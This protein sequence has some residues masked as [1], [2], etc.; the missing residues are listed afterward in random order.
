MPG[1]RTAC[2]SLGVALV[3]VAGCSMPHDA[4]VRFDSPQERQVFQRGPSGRAEVSIEGSATASLMA[5]QVRARLGDGRFTVWSCVA[6]Q[7][8]IDGQRRFGTTLSVPSG[9]WYEL[10]WREGEGDRK[11]VGVRR[12]GVGEVFVVAGQSNSTNCG[13][14]STPIYNDRVSAFDGQRWHHAHDPMPGVQDHT[15]GGSPWPQFADLLQRSLRVPVAVAS[16]GHGDSSILDWQPGIPPREEGVGKA[17]YPGLRDRLAAL[18]DIR[19]VLWHQGETDAREG[20]SEDEYVES[21]VR[22][23]DALRKDTGASPPWLVARVSFLPRNSEAA[24]LEIRRAQQRLWAEG[25]A[26]RGPDTDDLQGVLR[27]GDHTHFSRLGLEVHAER[28]FAMVWSELFSRPRPG[29]LSMHDFARI[30][31]H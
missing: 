10:Q 25:Y 16:V 5:L 2:F 14:P 11:R 7:R 15:T 22:L 1:I 26:L 12:F 17:L 9:G 3:L 18:G 19:A 30:A 31:Q 6:L 23:K 24:M 28:W 27:A 29:A 13:N 20:M 8:E 21:F 4:E